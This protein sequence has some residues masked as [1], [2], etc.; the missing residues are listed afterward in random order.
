MYEAQIAEYQD[1]LQ[2]KTQALHQMQRD[3]AQEVQHAAII[4]GFHITITLISLNL[5]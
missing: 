1:S 5:G 2:T 3:K 4:R